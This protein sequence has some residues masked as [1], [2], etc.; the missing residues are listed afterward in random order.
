[1]L[2]LSL[3]VVKNETTHLPQNTYAQNENQNNITITNLCDLPESNENVLQVDIVEVSCWQSTNVQICS[4]QILLLLCTAVLYR[5]K[6]V[7]KQA[8]RAMQKKLRMKH[9]WFNV[10]YR[11]NTHF[12]I[13][14]VEAATNTISECSVKTYEQEKTLKSQCHIRR[15]RPVGRRHTPE[16][17]LAVC[18]RQR[19]KV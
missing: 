9:S 17:P 11:S 7:M 15:A 13:H 6:I 12:K 4:R 5:S 1:M 10:L 16:P 14:F 2:S 3:S 18:Y 8:S 19:A